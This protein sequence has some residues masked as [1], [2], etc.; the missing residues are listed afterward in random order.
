MNSPISWVVVPLLSG[1]L[2]GDSMMLYY[3]WERR[4]KE[5]NKS[6]SCDT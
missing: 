2:V 1:L 3:I 6:G 4:K 5:K